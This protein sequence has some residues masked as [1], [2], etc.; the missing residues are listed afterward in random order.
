MKGPAEREASAILARLAHLAGEQPAAK[1]MPRPLTD[2]QRE[3][4]LEELRRQAHEIGAGA[5]GRG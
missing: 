2:Q 5:P 1:P 3:K 4:R